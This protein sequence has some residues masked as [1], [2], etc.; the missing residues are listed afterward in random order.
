MISLPPNN[1]VLR[2]HT[3]STPSSALSCIRFGEVLV[4]QGSPLLGALYALDRLTPAAAGKAALLAVGSCCLVGHVFVL[5]DWSGM[6][7]DQ[8]DPHRVS[9]VFVNRGVSSTTVGFLCIGFLALALVLLG[10]LGVLPLIMGL[11]IAGL[12]GLYSFPRAPMKGVPVLNSALHF[13]GGLLHFLLGYSVFATVDR[14]GIEIGCF[15]ALLFV[16]GHLTHETRDSEA[17][18]ANGIRTNAV[19]FGK[20]RS[21]LAGLILFG[22]AD[23]L[24]VTLA[25]GGRVPLVLAVVGATYPLHAYWWVK[26]LRKGLSFESVRWLQIRYRVLYAAVGMLMIVVRL[27]R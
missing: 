1:A 4:L 12:S 9:T 25:L 10:A 7:T 26:A 6:N 11:A 5:N 14:R 23:S 8:R 17:D 3:S 27:G 22:L 19:A 16:A 15:F 21:F 18:S 13:A 24:L 20:N 2:R